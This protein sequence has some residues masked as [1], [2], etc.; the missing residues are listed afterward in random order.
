MQSFKIIL[1][2]AAV[3]FSGSAG[4]QY[5]PKTISPDASAL[6]SK[7]IGSVD[8]G[9][10]WELHT[11]LSYDAAIA[12]A[13]AH[14]RNPKSGWESLYIKFSSAGGGNYDGA[15][16]HPTIA[17]RAAPNC[18][19]DTSFAA[20]VKTSLDTVRRPYPVIAITQSGQFDCDPSAQ[21][22]HQAWAGTLREA[23]VGADLP[24]H[25]F[26][27]VYDNNGNWIYFVLA[28]NAGLSG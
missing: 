16:Y 5:V 15:Y 8:I 9:G 3:T 4:A 24:R 13:V 23:G 17:G 18:P 19:Y 21:V 25:I 27:T 10:V 11:G 12:S 1:L 6:K 22:A 28:Y 2:A 20:Q 26:G 14:K 7:A